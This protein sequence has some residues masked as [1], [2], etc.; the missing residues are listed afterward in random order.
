MPKKCLNNRSG[1]KVTGL[2]RFLEY[3]DGSAMYDGS[4]YDVWMMSVGY[5]LPGGSGGGLLTQSNSGAT[6]RSPSGGKKSAL[7]KSQV[8]IIFEIVAINSIGAWLAIITSTFQISFALR[9]FVTVTF[10]NST[11]ITFCA[12]RIPADTSYIRW[13]VTAIIIIF[14]FAA[15][16]TIGAWF[17]IITSTFQFSFA[18]RIFITVTF[19]NFTRIVCCTARIIASANDI[20]RII[21]TVI[22]IIPIATR[23]CALFTVM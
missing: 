5:V 10:S 9:I 7:G 13:I 12:T 22:V 6:Q 18:F 15:I 17:A 4:F 23:F 20:C 1:A 11:W 21:A 2:T 3:S 19:S 14:E 8:I 16:Q